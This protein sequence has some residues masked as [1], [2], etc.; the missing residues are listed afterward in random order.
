MSRESI[1]PLRRWGFTL[2]VCA[3]V[4]W[5]LFPFAW[6]VVASFEPDRNL[7]Q[8]TPRWLPIPDGTLQHYRNV[9]GAKH[10]TRYM[11]NSLIVAACATAVALVFAT[12][13]AYVVTQR[14]MSGRGAI[15]A[16]VLCVSVF[17]QVAIVTPIYQA[18]LRLQL[19]NSY[20][21]LAAVHAGL[22][23]P[24]IFVVVANHFRTIPHEIYDAA[25]LDGAGPIRTLWSITVPLAAPGIVPAAL[26]GFIASWNE[27]L[28]ALSFVSSPTRQTAPVGIANFTGIYSIPWGDIAAAAVMTTTPLVI[29]VLICQRRI[30]AGLTAT[31]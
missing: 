23:L 28:L 29:L 17:P 31:G 13:A 22:S 7:A 4:G 30:V 6:Q 26:L 2:L 10:F 5:S 1:A 9:F 27:L 20:V 19:L 15:V 8:F 18:L 24:L 16:G 25:R 11:R 12:A 14:R 21:G 3:I